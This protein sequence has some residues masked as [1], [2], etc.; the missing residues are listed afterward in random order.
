MSDRDVILGRIRAALADVAA[1]EPAAFVA[2]EDAGYTDERRLPTEQLTR[3]F[4]ERCGEYR[5]NVVRCEDDPDAIRA[6]I[7]RVCERHGA[8]TLVAPADLDDRWCPAGVDARRDDPTLSLDELDGCDG[9]VSGCALAIA[10]TGTIVLDGGPAQGRRA[11]SLVPD[12]HICVV[13]GE[14]I[15]HGVPEAF[16]QL[17]PAV[18]NGRPITMISGPSATSDIELRR[19]EGVHGPRRLEVVLAASVVDG[20]ARPVDDD[21]RNEHGRG[22]RE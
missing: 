15:V 7:A 16:D 10:L 20:A 22:E 21:K 2:G 12:L 3:L 17:A 19:V 14:Q 13:R 18:Q 1:D 4:A 8:H 5:A 11:L 9:V 6:A